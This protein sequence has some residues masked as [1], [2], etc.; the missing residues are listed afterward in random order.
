VHEAVELGVSRRGRLAAVGRRRWGKP[1]L[2]A[3]AQALHDP[4]EVK[5]PDDA[6]D[7]SLYTGGGVL[8]KCGHLEVSS[9]ICNAHTPAQNVLTD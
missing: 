5:L 8:R 3:A 2:D 9:A 4:G 6:S 1:V 7:A